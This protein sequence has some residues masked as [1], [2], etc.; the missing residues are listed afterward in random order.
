MK[1]EKKLNLEELSVQS[2]TTELGRKDQKAV[3]GGS[4]PESGRTSVPTFC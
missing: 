2:F 4:A 3:K 1:Q